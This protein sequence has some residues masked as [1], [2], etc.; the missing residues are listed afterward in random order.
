MVHS[1]VVETTKKGTSLSFYDDGKARRIIFTKGTRSYI[2]FHGHFNSEKKDDMYTDNTCVQ[3][4]KRLRSVGYK[5]MA[6]KN[7]KSIFRP[8]KQ[9]G[10]MYNH[11]WYVHTTFTYKISGTF[12]PLIIL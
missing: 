10:T 1:F 12:I 5:F 11:K 9:V 4:I 3:T 6:N 7:N 8:S 2:D